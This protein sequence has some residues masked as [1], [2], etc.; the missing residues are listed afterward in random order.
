MDKMFKVLVGKSANEGVKGLLKC[1]ESGYV[2]MRAIKRKDDT[3]GYIDE[4]I[5]ITEL[6]W[7]KS[8]PK[9][10]VGYYTATW[11]SPDGETQ[12]QERAIT[13]VEEIKLEI[14]L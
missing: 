3:I 14:G 6:F 9:Q 12:Q 2:L 1:K 5:D 13:I 11:L 10:P 4:H 8:N 7:D